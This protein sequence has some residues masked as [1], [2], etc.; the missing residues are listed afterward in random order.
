MQ[1]V[2]HKQR[3]MFIYLKSLEMCQFRD[4]LTLQRV[5]LAKQVAIPPQ[6]RLQY[7]TDAKNK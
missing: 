2:Q 6:K 3:R 5:I 1:L 7:I 4:A